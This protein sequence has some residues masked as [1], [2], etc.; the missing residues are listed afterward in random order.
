MIAWEPAVRAA[1]L[2]TAWLLVATV[3]EP[4][5]VDPSKNCT[6]PVGVPAAVGF[7]IVAVNVTDWPTVEGLALLVSVRVVGPE[8]MLTALEVLPL[9]S[10]S[11]E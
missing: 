8:E 1:V 2:K 7:D 10:A 5:N 4:N 9:K 6:V 3:A 11:P